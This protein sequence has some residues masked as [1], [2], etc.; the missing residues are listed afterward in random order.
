[1]LEEYRNFLSTKLCSNTAKTYT[2]KMDN[3]LKGQDLI[4]PLEKLDIEMIINEL[5]KIKYKNYFSQSK[6]ALLYFL[7]FY[8][9]PLDKNMKVYIEDLEKKLARKNRK[10]LVVNYSDV[11]SRINH[12]RNKKLRLS[13]QVMLSTGLRVSELAQI[14][15]SD[16]LVNEKEIVFFFIGKGGRKEQTT[17]TKR[18][19]SRVYCNLKMSIESLSNDKKLFYSANYLQQK[20]ESLGFHCHDLR[21]LF[22]KLECQRNNSKEKTREKL[23]HTDIKTTEIYLYSKVKIK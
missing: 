5:S 21:R 11:V 12:I 6:N 7:E 19:Y 23:R 18:E 15:K 3:L 9:I 16:C 4:D 10:L 14:K 20:C 2:N 22:A 17:L 8:H 1:M 13:Y